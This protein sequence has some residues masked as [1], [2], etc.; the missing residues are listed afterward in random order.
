MGGKIKV[1]NK[2]KSKEAPGWR[3]RMYSFGLKRITRQ[4]MAERLQMRSQTQR[5]IQ[6]QRQ[7]HGKSW[8]RAFRKDLTSRTQNS[9]THL[10]VMDMDVVLVFPDVQNHLLVI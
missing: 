1:E 4:T 10:M 5:Q 9:P 7:R 2:V 3:R 6:R 8:L